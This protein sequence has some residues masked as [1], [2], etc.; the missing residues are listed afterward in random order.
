MI[1]DVMKQVGS[2]LP[3]LPKLLSSIKREVRSDDTENQ[4]T[5]LFC[6]GIVSQNQPSL[7]QDQFSSWLQ[8]RVPLHPCFVSCLCAFHPKQER[9][10]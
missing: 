10:L 3:Q 8:V 7:I 5:A 1:A 9:L 6:F 2:D 4:R